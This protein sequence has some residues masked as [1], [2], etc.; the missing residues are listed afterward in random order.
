M[1]RSCRYDSVNPCDARTASREPA[2]SSSITAHESAPV[3]A[4]VWRATRRNNAAGDSS[5]FN[6]RSTSAAACS[7]SVRIAT[8]ASSRPGRHPVR[9]ASAS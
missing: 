5:A 8:S 6:A 4:H 1:S 9:L 2:A 3:N 7:H